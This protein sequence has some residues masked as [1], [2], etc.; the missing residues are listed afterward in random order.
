LSYLC[1][2]VFPMNETMTTCAG[3]ATVEYERMAGF[4]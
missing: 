2:T 3:R 4:T 1:S